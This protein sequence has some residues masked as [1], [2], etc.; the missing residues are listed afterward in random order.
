MLPDDL[1]LT[2][3]ELHA[4]RSSQATLLGRSEITYESLY[5]SPKLSDE[6]SHVPTIYRYSRGEQLCLLEGRA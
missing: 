4:G 5:I 1:N 3:I 6:L 2:L